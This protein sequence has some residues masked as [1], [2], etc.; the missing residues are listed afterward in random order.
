MRKVVE[1]VM[2]A[3][4][5][6]IERFVESYIV[7]AI[8][9]G[10]VRAFPAFKQFEKG[11][12]PPLSK[13]QKKGGKPARRGRA[14]E[15][16]EE[17]LDDLDDL[18]DDQEEEE[19]EVPKKGSKKKAAAKRDKA[20]KERATAEGEDQDDMGAENEKGA[21][22]KPKAKRRGS[23][24]SEEVPVDAD[25]VLA[26]IQ[27]RRQKSAGQLE[28]LVGR[29]AAKHGKPQGDPELPD[30]EEFARIQKSIVNRAAAAAA[31]S[32]KN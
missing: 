9:A 3:E 27:K 25:K 18:D 28:A 11:A 22:K 21:R 30:E 2:L 23:K 6:D 19:E 32:R 10:Q 29:L 31:K 12:Q 5:A 26:E 24:K 16:E 20:K 17:D 1:E 4:T 8:A 13:K 15:E 7:P 14:K